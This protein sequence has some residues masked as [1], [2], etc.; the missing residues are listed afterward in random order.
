MEDR[1]RA[2]QAAPRAGQYEVIARDGEHTGIYRRGLEGKPLPPTPAKG[3]GYVYA[4]RRG[5]G[6]SGQ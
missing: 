3:Q 2:G 4:G 5:N 1:L 6:R